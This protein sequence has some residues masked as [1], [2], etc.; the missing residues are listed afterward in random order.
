MAISLYLRIDVPF[1]FA[2]SYFSGNLNSLSILLFFTVLFLFLLLGELLILFGLVIEYYF[3]FVF[4][5]SIFSKSKFN[6]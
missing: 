5:K 1:I 2:F 6:F 3:I 4:I